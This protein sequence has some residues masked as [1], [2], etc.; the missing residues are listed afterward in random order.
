M[1]GITFVRVRCGSLSLLTSEILSSSHLLLFNKTISHDAEL[2]FPSNTST[3][4]PSFKRR[5][6]IK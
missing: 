5:A 1:N 3:T 2:P 6:L 4:L